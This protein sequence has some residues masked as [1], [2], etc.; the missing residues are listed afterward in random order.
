M[1]SDVYNSIIGT[2]IVKEDVQQAR[3]EV[4]LPKGDT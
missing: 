1:G 4:L 2:V 3:A